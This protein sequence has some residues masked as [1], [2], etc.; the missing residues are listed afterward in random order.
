MMS[1]DI[2]V[3]PITD[4]DSCYRHFGLI[5]YTSYRPK[6]SMTGPKLCYVQHQNVSEH[7]QTHLGGA[8]GREMKKEAGSTFV[9]SA[10]IRTLC[11]FK[12][13]LAILASV[14]FRLSKLLCNTHLG[15]L[16]QYL[17]E[18]SGFKSHEE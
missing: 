12:I 14:S 11:L 10:I 1:R 8:N 16:L 5:I 17:S 15:C 2:L 4:F 13:I 7:L 6:T 9:L 3:L 18:N